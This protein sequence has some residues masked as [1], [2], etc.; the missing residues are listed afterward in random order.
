MQG[1]CVDKLVLVICQFKKQNNNN[2]SWLIGFNN[3]V[4]I[5]YIMLFLKVLKLLK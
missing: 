4:H 2:K 3:F 5:L 1:L